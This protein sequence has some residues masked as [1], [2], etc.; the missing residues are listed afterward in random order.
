MLIRWE[1]ERTSAP[2]VGQSVAVKLKLPASPVFGQRFMLFQAQVVR[3]SKAAD[4]SLMVALAGSPV[5][6]SDAIDAASPS[7][8]VN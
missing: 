8:Y 1:Q 2:I 3:V 6:F 7:G 5:R 4:E